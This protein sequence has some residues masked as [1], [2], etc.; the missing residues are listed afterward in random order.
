[1]RSKII[2]VFSGIV[3]TLGILAHLL[4]LTSLGD[5]EAQPAEMR[6]LVARQVHTA[7]LQWQA[8]AAAAEH[9]LSQKARQES[10]RA[11]FSLSTPRAQSRAATDQANHLIEASAA[12]GQLAVTPSLALFVDRQGIAVGRNSATLMRGDP[13]GEL[14]PGLLASLRAG[15]AHSDVWINE[16]RQEQLFVSSVPVHSSAGEI[17]G[18]VLLG[19]P[20]NDD[21]L[22][23]ISSL[24]SGGALAVVQR[25]AAGLQVL[26]R[27]SELTEA[28]PVTELEPWLVGAAE[29]RTI[30]QLEAPSADLW[31]A[32]QVIGLAA[33]A[34]VLSCAP[35][36][37]GER[38][39]RVLWTLWGG[40]SLGL[41]MVAIA[42]FV[43]GDY[44]SRPISEL[45]DGLLLVING[46]VGTRFDLDH[47][48]LGG[49]VSRINSVLDSIVAGGR[50][51]SDESVSA[52]EQ[53]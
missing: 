46:E 48:V 22:A 34:A 52:D 53:F 47:A 27:H 44:I 17:V 1:M 18:A 15:E 19:M 32:L 31:C 40:V 45:E 51:E 42:G 9:W 12:S 37:S 2:M 43:L 26:A 5:S 6:A 3:L 4:V 23:N 39:G 7:R 49:L 36:R 25:R 20:I 14:Y 13:L 33:D 24:T 10:V 16:S 30:E 50:S 35:F 8:N 29:S 28:L 21:A 38:A 11:V 41:L